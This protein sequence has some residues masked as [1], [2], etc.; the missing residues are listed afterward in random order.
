[1]KIAV[2]G[3]GPAGITAAYQLSKAIPSGKVKQLDVYEVSSQP[4]GLARS[5]ELFNQRVDLGPHRFFSHDPRINGLWLEVAGK[6]YDI[7]NR[8]TRI[9]YKNTFF[10][11]PIKAGNAL[12]GLGF[13]E[14]A[15][16][17]LS[18]VK[19]RIFPA[20]DE[21][22]FEAWVSN[23]FGVRLF[24]IFFKTYSEKLWG[25]SCHDLDK[26]FA[27][28]RIKKLSLFEAIK[29]A[30]LQGKDNKHQTLVDQFAYPTGGSGSIYEKMTK[31]IRE[32]G[33]NI[34]F[35]RGVEKVI[36]SGH[37]VTGIQLTSGEN[38]EYNQVIST[39]PIS[40]LVTR[41]P[42]TPH[43]IR[44]MANSLKFRN[45]ILV[46]LRINSNDLFPDQW[47]YIHSAE[48]KTGRITN[49]R[50]WV[51]Q[52]YGD[53]KDTILCMEY[54]C[55]FE[56]PE[57]QMTDEEY[58][59]LGAKEIK[60]TGLIG[61]GEVLEGKV[62]RLPRCYPVYF[63]GYK[64]KLKPVENYLEG[65]RN[66]QAIGRYGSYKYNNQDHSIFMGILAAENILENKNHNL[67]E[68]N[69][70]YETYQESSVITKTGLVKTE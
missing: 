65:I 40:L 9:F 12:K 57:W 68:I 15:L 37:V 41:L 34:Y 61:D 10:N 26:D 23:R 1:M 52:L 4:G 11:Y 70:D 64:E 22:T 59:A 53:E 25:I 62:V 66:L 60:M 50:N 54:W 67:W 31:K 48:L 6:D 7:V 39:M 58:V 20:R 19:Q 3:A 27:A 16:C 44:E 43:D 2:I 38:L 47:L 29:N 46:Y 33:G 56:D 55:N 49:F 30:L 42:E 69:T 14:A 63:R 28:Q 13:F 18:Y 36:S 35:K 45:T 21:S 8:Q 51:P 17:V 5:M 24:R 32:N